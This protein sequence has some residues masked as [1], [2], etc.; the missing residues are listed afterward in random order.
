MDW[1]ML[2]KFNWFQ[3]SWMMLT[4]VR[5]FCVGWWFQPP[6]KI[7]VRLDHHPNYW[8]HVP[9]HQRVHVRE[10]PNFHVP[11]DLAETTVSHI[12][13]SRRSDDLRQFGCPFPV[14]NDM[15]WFGCLHKFTSKNNVFNWYNG[16]TRQFWREEPV[17]MKLCSIFPGTSHIAIHWP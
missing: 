12:I 15:R 9:N 6:W 8:E 1:W 7:L 16:I 5:Q 14:P 10:T 3:P 2:P 13:F 11:K 17:P 4:D